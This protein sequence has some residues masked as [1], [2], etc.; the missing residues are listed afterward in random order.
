MSSE[1]YT[2]YIYI[3]SK[4]VCSTVLP[5][6]ATAAFIYFSLGPATNIK[7]GNYQRYF[8]NAWQVFY[9]GG[10]AFIAD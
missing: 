4:Q 7:G 1:I 2:N 5:N 8:N 9:L 3:N 10:A 6:I